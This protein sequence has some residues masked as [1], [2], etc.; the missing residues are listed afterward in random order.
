MPVLVALTWFGVL[1]ACAMAV[2]LL[3]V[4]CVSWDLLPSSVLARVRWWHRHAPAVLVVST[5][6]ALVGGALVAWAP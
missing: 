2:Y 5:L 3:A 4:R 1:G 6:V